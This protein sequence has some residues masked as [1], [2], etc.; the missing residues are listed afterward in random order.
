M[1]GYFSD[2]IFFWLLVCYLTYYLYYNTIKCVAMVRENFFGI[3]FF[4]GFLLT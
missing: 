2:F 4:M 3:H 1:E